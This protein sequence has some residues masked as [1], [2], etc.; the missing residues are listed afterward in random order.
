[1]GPDGTTLPYSADLDLAIELATAAADH[2]A[3]GDMGHVVSKSSATDPVTAVDQESERLVVEGLRH[4]RP[5]DAIVGEEGA[6]HPGRSGRRWIVDPLD[7][8]VNYLYGYPHHAVSIA[9]EDAGEFVLGVIH[10]SA[11]N[12]VYSAQRGGGANVDGR[13]MEVRDQAHNI[14]ECLLATGFAYDSSKRAVQAQ[15]LTGILPLVRDIRRSGSCALDLCAVAE[16]RVD[17][18]YEV[19][20]NLW[21]VAAGVVIV[22]EA[23]GQTAWDPE[24][25]RITASAPQL[26]DNLNKL[27]DAAEKISDSTT[28]VGASHFYGRIRQQ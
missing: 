16:G 7:G 8:T 17:A 24:R 23:G 25:G 1:M 14:A 18:M 2:H 3:N 26:W 15:V 13:P 4:H 12:R 21:D 5:D 20:P 22:T 9:M 10:D 11:S 28:P 19:G 27:L 6:N